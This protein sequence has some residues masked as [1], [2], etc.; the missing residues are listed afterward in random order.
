MAQSTPPNIEAFN[1]VVA[2]TLVK[3]YEAFPGKVSLCPEAVGVEVIKQFKLSGD[4]VEV[5]LEAA[6]GSIEFLVDEGFIVCND[7]IRT[8]SGPQFPDA[9]LTLK[10]L[11]L[12]GK[13]PD[14]VAEGAERQSFADQL[15]SVVETGAKDSATD[16]VK[17]L[18]GY[19]VSIG[20]TAAT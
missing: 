13:V 19:A 6:P 11:N 12:L 2:I 8:Y 17:Q 20:V 14:S 18:L 15:R 5:T 3:L 16:I 10:G 9:K 1:Q 7:R 4:S